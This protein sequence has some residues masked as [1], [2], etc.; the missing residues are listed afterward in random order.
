[1]TRHEMSFRRDMSFH[2]AR[3]KFGY[4]APATDIDFLEYDNLEPVLLWEAK[5]IKSRWRNG[6]RTASMIVQ[7]KLSKL[8]GIPYVVVEHNDKWSKITVFKIGGWKHKVPIISDERKMTLRQFVAWLYKIRGRTI[9]S[10]LNSRNT[11]QTW[12]D[13]VPNELEQIT[14]GKI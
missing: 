5:S 9:E 2:V 12:L 6:R 3:R 8:A 10:E 1:M 4:N 13:I 11:K 7:W 14:F